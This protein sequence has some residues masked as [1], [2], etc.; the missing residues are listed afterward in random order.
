MNWTSLFF[1]EDICYFPGPVSWPFFGNQFLLN[2]LSR[3][4]GGQHKAFLE[5]SKR[6]A[7]DVIT[8]T[9]GNE[10]MLVISG[11]KLCET[12]LKND[13]FEG[14]PWNEFI[15]MRNMGKKQGI[16]IQFLK[17]IINVDSM[18]IIFSYKIWIFEVWI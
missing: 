16:G 3:E 2:R 14:R 9:I 4:L 15:K 18:I 8:L 6:Y 11:F 12:I 7:S 17:Y 5:L 13:E 10:K 1:F